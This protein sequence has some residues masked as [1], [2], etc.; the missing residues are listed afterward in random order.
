MKESL[1]RQKEKLPSEDV[2]ESKRQKKFI[3]RAEKH[4]KVC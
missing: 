2:K 3:K 1:S 4:V